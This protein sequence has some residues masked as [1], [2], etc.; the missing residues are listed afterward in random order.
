MSW[1]SFPY[2]CALSYD[3][4]FSLSWSIFIEKILIDSFNWLQSKTALSQNAKR[5]KNWSASSYLRLQTPEGRMGFI[6]QIVK[7][8]L[9]IG[10]RLKVNKSICALLYMVGIWWGVV[11][12]YESQHG[13]LKNI[14]F[15]IGCDST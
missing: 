13:H 2:S 4:F 15:R 9:F 5:N 6:F 10:V 11:G 3:F 1:S 12:G 14:I 8:I 7:S